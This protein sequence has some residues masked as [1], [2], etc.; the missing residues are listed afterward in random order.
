ML[1][2]GVIDPSESPLCS[3]PVLVSKPDES[4]RFCID[5]YQLNA[6]SVFDVYPMPHVEALIDCVAGAKCLSAIDLTKEYWQ[7]PLDPES[8]EKTAST[9]PSGLYQFTKMPFG[10]HGT[11]ASFQR[12]MVCT[13]KTV[14]DCT[15]IYIDDIL[16]FSNS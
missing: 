16:F 9:T 6:V 11:A 5:F 4:V 3:P 13:L 7:I 10:L 1:Q 12:L 8:K 2:L 15:G 14:R